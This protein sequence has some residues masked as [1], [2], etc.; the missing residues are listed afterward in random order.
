MFGTVVQ[1]PYRYGYESVRILAGL[2]RDQ[3]VLPEGGVLDI[4]ARAIRSDNVRAFWDE[5]EATL[6][7]K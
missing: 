7:G 6:A 1:N 4:P 3:D 2:A 5:L